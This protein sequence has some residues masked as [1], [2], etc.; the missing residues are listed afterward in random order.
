M[1]CFEQ[2]D[3]YTRVWRVSCQAPCLFVGR[4]RKFLLNVNGSKNERKRERERKYIRQSVN[5]CFR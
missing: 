1:D 2:V 3:E 5:V 4:C